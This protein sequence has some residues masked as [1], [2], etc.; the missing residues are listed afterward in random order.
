MKTKQIFQQGVQKVKCC[1]YDVAERSVVW[2]EVKF[3]FIVILKVHFQ[4]FWQPFLA[5]FLVNNFS[6]HSQTC[7]TDN[8]YK[9]TTHLRQPMLSPTKQIPIQSLPHKM[10]TCLTQLASNFLSPKWK[11]TCLKQ[12]L[13]RFT[14]QWNRKQT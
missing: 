9:M 13:K 2:M 11:K 10:T 8:L 4:K 3:K 14:Q 6:L 5:R 12:P 1:A 7:S